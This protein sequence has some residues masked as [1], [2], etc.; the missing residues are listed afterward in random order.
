MKKIIAILLFAALIAGGA[1]AQLMFG[2]TGDLHT[3]ALNTTDIQNSFQT[4]QNIFYGPFAELALGKL[5]FG[6]SGTFSFY[7]I[8]NTHF[9]DYDVAAYIS[10]HLF[11]AR[12]FLDPFLQFGAG[13]IATDYANSTDKIASTTQGASDPLA[14]NIYWYGAAGVGVNLGT[15]GVFGK[16]AYNGSVQKHLPGT[17]FRPDPTRPTVTGRFLD[18]AYGLPAGTC[19][20]FLASA[21]TV[22]PSVFTRGR[23]SRRTSAAPRTRQASRGSRPPRRRS[24]AWGRR[25]CRRGCRRTGHT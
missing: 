19:L 12:S 14:A 4:G 21:C 1:F 9:M 13:Y 15:I 18:G 20:P 10:Y 25:R 22:A 6:A 17:P 7:D 3:D 8:Y 16:A 24:P 2:V 11:G 5:G 23:R